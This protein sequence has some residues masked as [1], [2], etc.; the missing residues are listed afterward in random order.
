MYHLDFATMLRLVQE[1]RRNGSLHTELQVSTLNIK[2]LCQAQIVL[3]EG[4]I[5]SCS[6]LNKSGVLLFESNDALRV[7]SR[8][9]A[10]DWIWNQQQTRVTRATPSVLQNVPASQPQIRASLVPRRLIQPDARTL[11]EW[12]REYIRVFGLIDGERN[13]SKIAAMLSIPSEKLEGVLEMLHKLQAL[14]FITM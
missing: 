11:S 2:E 5:A 3:V 9:G 13:V 8:A 14:G 1:F 6:I 12:P 7:L 4:K 10:L